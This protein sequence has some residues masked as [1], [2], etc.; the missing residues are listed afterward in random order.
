[1]FEATLPSLKDLPAGLIASFN[2]VP[3]QL[4]GHFVDWLATALKKSGVSAKTIA[5]ECT[6]TALVAAT[7]EQLDAMAQLRLL[8]VTIWLD[9]FAARASIIDL[10]RL[11]LAG[12]KLARDLAAKCEEDAGQATIKAAL[13]LARAMNRQ[14]IAVGVENERQRGVLAGLG[15]DGLQGNAIAAPMALAEMNAWL[16]KA[17]K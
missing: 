3:A 4:D 17:G 12:L 10:Q 1:M 15:V 2:V 7:Q 6:E 9:E 14:I 11:P 13:A 5:L 8:G 16:Q